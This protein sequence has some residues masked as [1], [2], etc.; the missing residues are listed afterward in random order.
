MREGM[1]I[2]MSKCEQCSAIYDPTKIIFLRHILS[3][4]E[5]RLELVAERFPGHHVID[6]ISGKCAFVEAKW[7]DEL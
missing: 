7:K 2:P 3:N 6:G 5:G 1:K 4:Q